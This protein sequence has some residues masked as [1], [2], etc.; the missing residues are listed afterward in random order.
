MWERIAEYSGT[1]NTPL[2]LRTVCA[3]CVDLTGMSGAWVSG[4][5]GSAGPAIA[6]DPLAET[7]SDLQVLLGEGPAADAVKDGRP[8]A[9]TDVATVAS[10]RVWPLFARAAADSGARAMLV[11]PIR[12]GTAT[13]GLFGLYSRVPTVLVTSQ[14]A[15][16]D[17][18]AGV[19]LGLLLDGVHHYPSDLRRHVPDGWSPVHPE[20][21]QA[22]GIVSVQLGLDVAE[23]LVCLRAH[24]YAQARPLLE[25]AREIVTR[26]RR[27]RPNTSEPG[28]GAP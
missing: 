17:A 8:V 1:R 27:F 3:V 22:T 20:I 24:A 21:H 26:R 10:R 25:I 9:V 2:S 5:P 23:A 15:E 18:F 19:A 16:V 28:I 12:V 11:L 6:T 13:I 7:L 14:R 4:L